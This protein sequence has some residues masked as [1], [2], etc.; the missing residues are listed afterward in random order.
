MSDTP[1]DTSPQETDQ[2]QALEQVLNQDEINSLLSVQGG[3]VAGV[4]FLIN[5]TKISHERLPML[6]VV[7][8]RLSGQL[9]TRLRQFC[10]C[11]VD[12][13]TQDADSVRFGEY[14]QTITPPTL[15]IIFNIAQWQKQG[16]LII[17]SDLTLTLIDM[18]LGGRQ[19]ATITMGA[20][21]TFTTIEKNLVR[22]FSKIVLEEFTTAFTSIESVTFEYERTE[23]NPKFAS[24]VRPTDASMLIPFLLSFEG[25]PAHCEFC[26]PYA[27]I[28]PVREK[29]S[30]SFTGESSGEDSLWG[31][32]LAEEVWD[33]D[34]SM[35]AILGTTQISL[36][37][38][39]RWKK[40]S[41][42]PLRT[43]PHSVI[44]LVVKDLK[45]ISGKMGKRDGQVSVRVEENWV[46]KKVGSH[47]S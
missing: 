44:D 27:S 9:S 33:A 11:P 38:A 31:G 26:V 22:D 18:L 35:D 1:T 34:V 25:R 5:N 16:L 47:E 3:E 46:K 29:V 36:G 20:E 12:V 30:R 8:E 28:E 13:A 39:L 23:T 10:G 43:K 40:G 7:F 2:D 6:E 4:D 42:L 45:T 21:R 14:L 17:K 15:I 32:H 19:E 37:E 24:I 41:V